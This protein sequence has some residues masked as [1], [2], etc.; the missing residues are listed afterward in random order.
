M[1]VL[2]TAARWSPTSNQKG[3]FKQ[4]TFPGLCTGRPSSGQIPHWWQVCKQARTVTGTRPCLCV[5]VCPDVWAALRQPK[6]MLNF[7][8]LFDCAAY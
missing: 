4:V 2:G 3:D 8:S 5:L 7:V 1:R 6:L